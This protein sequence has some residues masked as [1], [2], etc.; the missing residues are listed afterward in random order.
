MKDRTVIQFRCT[1][2]FK[3]EI[4]RLAVKE[5]RTVSNY[6]INLVDKEIEREK[7]VKVRDVYHSSLW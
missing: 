6:I 2:E 1:S 7:E 5:N 3:A 4:E